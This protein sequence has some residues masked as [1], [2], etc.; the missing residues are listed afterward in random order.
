MPTARC[1]RATLS[2]PIVDLWQRWFLATSQLR[3]D[4]RQ[5]SLAS[6]NDPI[7]CGRIPHRIL[8]VTN[9]ML[10]CLSIAVFNLALGFA[11]AVYLKRQQS[12]AAPVAEE[13][14][15]EESASVEEV[16][17][18][19]FEEPDHDS[20]PGP[21]CVPT[22]WTETLFS[23]AI[24]SETLV[25]AS[26]HILRLRAKEFLDETI[27]LTVSQAAIKNEDQ[28]IAAGE[29]QA[30]LNEGA[31]KWM[32]F[33][34]SVQVVMDKYAGQFGKLG[35]VQVHLDTI[36]N[37]HLL[38]LNATV[39]KI[40]AANLG[41]DFDVASNTI[42]EALREVIKKLAEFLDYVDEMFAQLIACEERFDQV[43]PG[44]LLDTETNLLNRC[45]LEQT[46]HEWRT[47]ASGVVSAICF[48]I[49][50]FPILSHFEDIFIGD[51]L[52][53]A[54][55]R[56]LDTNVRKNR[57]FDR[58]ARFS[59]G[60]I[61]LL[62]GDTE[63]STACFPAERLRSIIGLSHF[64]YGRSEMQL[65]VSCVACEITDCETLDDVNELLEAGFAEARAESEDANAP[66]GNVTV[67]Y[68]DQEYKRLPATL[69]PVRTTDV[70]ID[71][72]Q[73]ETPQM[74]E[75]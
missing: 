8:P 62:L 65:T 43:D 24:A 75:A 4:I 2:C 48:E 53:Q 42:T 69:D 36:L 16:E 58:L 11:L 44:L 29:V 73:A 59:Y 14:E 19:D 9:S 10:L 28:S 7:A 71:V 72:R 15:S 60:R 47:N 70:E 57:G 30:R 38:G 41:A 3:V 49:D 13:E 20:T 12:V 64:N 17:D 1:S 33:L 40:K 74:Q 61:F 25:E 27:E 23:E 35:E 67:A 45:G 51:R 50:D 55:A 18:E 26:I 21:E 32:E 68:I 66:S 6:V 46:L 31:T 56:V 5:E 37:A 63:A 54:L 22:K 52:V 39:E 34:Q